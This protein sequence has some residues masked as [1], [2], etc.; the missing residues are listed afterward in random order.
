MLVECPAIADQRA[1]MWDA[2]SYAV[3]SDARIDWVALLLSSPDRRLNLLLLAG[4][5]PPSDPCGKPL[6]HKEAPRLVR[7]VLSQVHALWRAFDAAGKESPP[8]PTP[9]ACEL[10]DASISSERSAS[11]TPLP[12]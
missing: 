7:A 8:S 11:L 12:W 1:C 2:I 9:S 6:E 3:R 10:S 5:F 4:P